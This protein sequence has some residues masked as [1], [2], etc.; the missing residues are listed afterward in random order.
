MSSIARSERA[1]GRMLAVGP[2]S[3][4]VA[5]TAARGPPSVL[6]HMSPTNRGRGNRLPAPQN[7]PTFGEEF[8]PQC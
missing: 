7:R 2:F 4:R 6:A 3:I 5:N 1:K 8:G